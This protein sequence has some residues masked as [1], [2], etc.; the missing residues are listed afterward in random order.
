VTYA[1][2]TFKAWDEKGVAPT[3][4]ATGL[5]AV[6]TAQAYT[7]IDG[8]RPNVGDSVRFWVDRWGAQVK[9]IDPAGATTLLA[10]GNAA[11]P[12]LVTRIQYPNGRIM[13]SG[14]NARGNVLYVADSTYEGTTWSAQTVTTSF[15][16]DDTLAFPDSPTRISTPAETTLIAYHDSLG[17][18]DTITAPGGHRTVFTY[19]LSPTS[20]RGRVS[21]VKELGVSV[22]DTTTWL[23]QNKNLTTSF[24][25]DGW[26]N[27]SVVT[28]PRGAQTRYE[29]DAYRRVARAFDPQNHWTRYLYDLLNQPRATFFRDTLTIPDS[30]ATEFFYNRTGMVTSTDGP[31]GASFYGSGSS[32]GALLSWEFDAAERPVRSKDEAQ[33]TTHQYFGPSGLL[34]SLR[35]GL[36]H[37]IRYFY[38]LPRETEQ[39]LGDGLRL[40]STW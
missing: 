13:G 22:V 40:H 1:V 6:D 20:R 8:P 24:L 38:D 7:M 11:V 17:L 34:D 31:K 4:G 18:P 19:F 32:D 15:V 16:Y 29:Y 36:D 9:V 27:D 25:Y 39:L 5:I 12:A 35:T 33:A 14:Y 2:T 3:N 21:Q 37:V 10:R 26:G 23:K 30:I 28:S